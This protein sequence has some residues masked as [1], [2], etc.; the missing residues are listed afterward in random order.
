MNSTLTP[1]LL[2]FIMNC[3]STAKASFLLSSNVSQKHST[4]ADTLVSDNISLTLNHW[5]S[6]NRKVEY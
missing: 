6:E 3:L 1:D 4:K 2:Q 5:L